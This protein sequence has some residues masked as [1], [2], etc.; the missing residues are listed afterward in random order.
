MLWP[1]HSKHQQRVLA[2][3]PNQCLEV[4]SHGFGYTNHTQI[5]LTEAPL[6]RTTVHFKIDIAGKL[7]LVGT[8]I[9]QVVKRF[10]EVYLEELKTHC[11]MMSANS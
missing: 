4:I 7:P 3:I 2:A 11:G 9:G 6:S 10:M 1:L 5:L 8:A